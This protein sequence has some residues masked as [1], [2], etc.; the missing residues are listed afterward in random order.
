MDVVSDVIV[1][2]GWVQCL[3]VSVV[4]ILEDETWGLRLR[5]SDH[6]KQLYDVR[7]STK[8]L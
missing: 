4:N 5:V 2:Q 3:E 6:I 7:A 8:I 1:H